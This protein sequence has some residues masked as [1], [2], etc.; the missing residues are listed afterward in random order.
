MTRLGQMIFDDGIREGIKE[1]IKEGME[2]G[3]ETKLIRQ[4]CCKLIKGK[5]I[6]MIADELEEDPAVITR[7]CQVAEEF[8]PEYDC[9]RIYQKLKG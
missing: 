8:A 7:I 5:N 3:G 6:S 1:G 2:R 4:V 9:E